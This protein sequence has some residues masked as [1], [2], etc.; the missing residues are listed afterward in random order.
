MAG[1]FSQELDEK[2]IELS[3]RRARECAEAEDYEGAWDAARVL[4]DN[5]DSD[6][7]ARALAWLLD[8]GSFSPTA[9]LQV[10]TLLFDAHSEDV[11]MLCVL[12]EALEGL[13]DIDWLNAAPP[14]HPLFQQVIG[15]L[16]AVAEDAEP[17]QRAPIMRSLGMAAKARGRAYDGVAEEAG[18]LLI[19]LEP[20]SP[21]SHY[22][23]GLFYKTRGRFAEGAE[24]NQRAL[25]L[26]A[27]DPD[28]SVIWNLGICATGARDADTALKLWRDMGHTIEVGRFGL[29]DGGYPEVKVRLAERPLAERDFETDPD[30]PGQE[31][32]IWVERVSPCHGIVRSVLI[33]DLGV[34]FGDA[35]LFDGAPITHHKYGE[36][37]VPVFPHLVTLEHANY[38]LYPF[39][40]SQQHD[41]QLGGLSADLPQEIVIYVHTEQVVHYCAACWADPDKDHADHGDDDE[42]RFVEGKISAP[43]DMPPAELLALIDDAVGG[44]EGARLFSP[45][46]CRAAGEDKRAEVEDRRIAMMNS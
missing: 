27:D 6:D 21:W 31:E 14:D 41:E 35:V 24:A 29:P 2:R 19:E 40:G 23:L 9:G 36:E 30:D 28:S 17:E 43:P 10:A 34:N 12:G 13:S 25:E 33:N 20:D 15:A 7:P 45:Q 46:L 18:K 11:D 39:A 1:W 44:S 4:R 38:Q 3:V 37:V 16:I 8:Q 32:T 22:N 42:H 26:C 5:V